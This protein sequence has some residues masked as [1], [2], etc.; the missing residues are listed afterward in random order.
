MAAKTKVKDPLQGAI[1]F[2]HGFNKVGKTNLAYGFPQPMLF[3]ATERGHKYASPTVKKG[4]LSLNPETGWSEFK[5]LPA[6]IRGLKQIKTV[7]IDVVDNLYRWACYDIMAKKHPS[8]GITHPGD[9]NDHG[10]SWDA[11]KHGFTREISLVAAAC[12][13]IG[14][15]LLMLSQSVHR[16]ITGLDQKYDKVMTALPGQ[17]QGIL[18]AEP[19]DIWHLSFG[20]EH[21]Q[22]ILHL[23]GKQEIQCGSRSP[24]LNVATVDLPRDPKQA[25]KAV[26]LAYLGSSNNQNKTQRKKI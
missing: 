2:L 25:Y 24:T 13:K 20:A 8:G 15:T 10:A 14:A 23:M 26:A 4:M 19:D 3:I 16:E 11:L 7:C 21:D 22:R 18:L 1:I 9:A 5:K 6:K 17:A 12:E